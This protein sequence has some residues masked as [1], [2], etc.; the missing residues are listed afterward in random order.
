MA[1]RAIVPADI[2]IGDAWESAIGRRLVT[3]VPKSEYRGYGDVRDKRDVAYR[4]VTGAVMIALAANFLRGRTL[5]E[6][7]GL[8]IG[9]VRQDTASKVKIL[10][11][12]G[13]EAVCDDADGIRTYP[14][15]E[16]AALPL[17]SRK[18]P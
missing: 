3:V 11:L 12:R 14:A 15:A 16:I 18:E 13:D 5:H 10:V 7:G 17:V 1:T 9:D 6:R 8:R 2:R 4:G